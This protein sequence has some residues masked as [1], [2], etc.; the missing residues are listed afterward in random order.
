MDKGHFL[1]KKPLSGEK[2]HR[3]KGLISS[4]SWLDR[5]VH[6]GGVGAREREHARAS[7]GR[8]ESGLQGQSSE[9]TCITVEAVGSY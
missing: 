1:C 2:A 7:E 5:T 3:F 9:E 8:D 6:M 4:V